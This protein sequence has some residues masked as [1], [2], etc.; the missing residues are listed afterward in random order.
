MVQRPHNQSQHLPIHLAL[1]SVVVSWLKGQL[2]T[3]TIVQRRPQPQP[4]PPHP[5][6]IVVRSSFLVKGTVIHNNNGTEATTVTVNTSPSTWH[7]WSIVSPLLM[8]QSFRTISLAIV[9]LNTYK[10]HPY[11][12]ACIPIKRPIH[13]INIAFWY[14]GAYSES[15]QITFTILMPLALFTVKSKE[16]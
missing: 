1:W 11:T 10:P 15:F 14:S 9:P 4:K 6:G 5:L 13:F 12:A 2:F 7:L 16:S 8:E 3:T